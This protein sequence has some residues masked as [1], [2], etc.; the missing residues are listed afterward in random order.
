[1]KIERVNDKSFKFSKK[2][3]HK[4]RKKKSLSYFKIITIPLIFFLIGLIIGRN[5]FPK[6]NYIK[7]IN[8]SYTNIN[9]PSKT[10]SNN[11][12]LTA[13]PNIYNN[14]KNIKIGSKS[15]NYISFAQQLEDLILYIFLYDVEKGFYIDVGANSPMFDSV[16]RNFYE[17][18]WNGINIEPLDDKY[19]SLIQNRKRDINLKMVASDKPG[20]VILYLNDQL[21]TF[22]KNL[23]SSYK[24]KTIKAD[25][26]AN[27]CK[28]YVPK[29]T[30]IEFCKIDVEGAELKVLMGYDFQNYRPKVFCMESYS[31]K[32]LYKTYKEFEPIFFKNNYSFAYKNRVNRYYIDN[33][34][35]YLKDR[36]K[37]IDGA[38]EDYIAKYNLDRKVI[39]KTYWI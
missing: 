13:N 29:N 16:T 4:K 21:T 7:N 20:E 30:P 19:E 1:M 33:T 34:I 28:K 14:S 27:I 39:L 17:N 24:T 23:A 37:L 5:F 8:S 10:I 38:I 35:E 9:N 15:V 32:Y 36:I 31:P 6:N 3:Y 12:I 2:S 18:G 11:N 26:M 25:T 22:I